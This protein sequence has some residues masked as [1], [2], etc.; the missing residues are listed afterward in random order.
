MPAWITSLL[1]ELTPVQSP[2]A[3][4]DDHFAP[5]PSE[6][7][8]AAR[9]MTPAPT[10]RHSTDSIP[11][12][13]APSGAFPALITSAGPSASLQKTWLRGRGRRPCPAQFEM[14][15][16][17]IL[18]NLT[19]VGRQVL[20]CASRSRQVDHLSPELCQ[21]SSSIAGIRQQ[22]FNFKGVHQIG[23]TPH[24]NVNRT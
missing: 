15:P 8:C 5:G 9:P 6:R 1:R 16:G 20:G 22:K 23:S 21:I 17:G 7:S 11:Q 13:F 19:G 24:V 3:F 18:W 14:R 2:L 12:L 4:N 10:T